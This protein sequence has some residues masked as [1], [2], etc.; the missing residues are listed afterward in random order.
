LFAPARSAFNSSPF[1]PRQRKD[2]FGFDA[3]LPCVEVNTSV[4]DG[5]RERSI[6]VYRALRDRSN[7]DDAAPVIQRDRFLALGIVLAIPRDFRNR[8]VSSAVVTQWEAGRAM[9]YPAVLA[10]W[11]PPLHRQHLAGAVRQDRTTEQGRDSLSPARDAP[12]HPLTRIGYPA[13]FA[14]N[15]VC[16]VCYN[17]KAASA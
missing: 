6:D 1:S 12:F 4:R 10:H 13:L 3:R 9:P 5:R 8:G 11:V 16:A 14:R 17:S 15:A 2:K 7:K